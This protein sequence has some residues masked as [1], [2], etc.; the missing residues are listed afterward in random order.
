MKNFNSKPFFILMLITS[1]IL[2][3]QKED[4]TISPNSINNKYKVPSITSVK[5]NF[6]AKAIFANFNINQEILFREDG[7]Q[8]EM[9]WD[10]STSKKYK[11]P[12]STTPQLD[13]LY[14]PIS[15]NTK[16]NAKLFLASIEEDNVLKSKIMCLIYTQ[17]NN[18]SL[19]S[20][21]VLIFNLN[22]QLEKKSKYEDGNKV[23]ITQN[24]RLA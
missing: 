4:D 10:K 12:I 8:I 6:N 23:E 22:G 3:C 13:I 17:S 15:L 11:E 19:F 18:I 21:Y 9:D 7:P 14:T 20:G 24:S 16:G 5:Q 1:C 2:S